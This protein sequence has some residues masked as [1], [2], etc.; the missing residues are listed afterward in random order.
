MRTDDLIDQLAAAPQPIPAGA[1]QRRFAGVAVAGALA[2]LVMVLAWLGARQDL[3]QAMAGRMF[4]MKA[5]YTG[6]LGLAGFWALER[7]ARPEGV[8]RKALL[9]GALVLALFVGL[10]LGQWLAADWEHRRS[11]MMG[12]SWKVCFR[13][14]LTLALPGLLATLLVLRRMAPTRPALAGF[15]A[16]AFAGGVAATV[17]GLHCGESTMVFVGTWYTLG[18]L[19][20]GALGAM[21]GRWMLRW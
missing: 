13:Y 11:M 17:Y 21:I 2:A 20:T 6:L 19:G 12:G 15:A 16:G 3:A 10:G 5:T 4:W 18:V 1:V 14:I 8:P 9:F 7:L